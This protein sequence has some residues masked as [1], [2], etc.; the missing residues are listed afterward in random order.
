[1]GRAAVEPPPAAAGAAAAA[2]LGD[3]GDAAGALGLPA[4]GAARGA[5]A[6]GGAAALVPAPGGDGADRRGRGHR[7]GP[8]PAVLP[9]R[10]NR[11]GALGDHRRLRWPA[12]DG[13]ARP[14]RP[15]WARPAR[16]PR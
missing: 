4:A 8:G 12:D 16:S 3:A 10:R 11:T 6:P 1:M 14:P 7:A 9:W 15:S 13:S 5:A 2:A